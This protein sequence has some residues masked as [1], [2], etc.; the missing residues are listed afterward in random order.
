[1]KVRFILLGAMLLMTV[2]TGCADDNRGD[3]GQ[4]MELGLKIENG[5]VPKEEK[6]GQRFMARIFGSG[7]SRKCWIPCL[8]ERNER[9]RYR[10]PPLR[11]TMKMIGRTRRCC[12]MTEEKHGERTA[13]WTEDFLI[14]LRKQ[15]SI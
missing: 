7:T 2:L 5:I 11:I 1:M 4:S 15:G 12:C 9:K 10:P 13:V 6:S 3:V 14:A 8:E